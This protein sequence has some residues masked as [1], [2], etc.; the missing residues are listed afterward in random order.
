MLKEFK[1]I[2]PLFQKLMTAPVWPITSDIL[3]EKHCD[4][5]LIWAFPTAAASY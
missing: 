5:L 1:E 3:Q 4:K 2:Q